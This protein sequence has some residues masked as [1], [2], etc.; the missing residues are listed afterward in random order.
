MIYNLDIRKNYAE[1]RLSLKTLDHMFLKAVEDGANCSPF[2]A[3]AILSIVKKIYPVDIP[4]DD[5]NTKPGQMKVI[6]ISSD[7]P[8]GKPLSK[9]RMKECI[10]TIHNGKEDDFIRST[11]GVEG[12]R[13][14]VVLRIASQAYE[15][16]VLLTQEDIAFHILHCGRRTLNRDIAYFKEHNI[17]VPTR[18][19]KCDIGPGVSHK[20]KSV[21][22]LFQRKNEYEIA[23]L[24][25]HTVEAIER[26]TQT[27]I[28]IAF[29]CRQGFDPVDIAFTLH[30]SQ[31]LAS[32]YIE[33]YHKYNN[34]DYSQIL[35]EIIDKHPDIQS[36]KI[37][38]D[39]KKFQPIYPLFQR[40][41]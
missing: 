31:R 16:G 22:L 13:R 32:Q 14:A 23:R 1:Q 29:L 20:V 34:N 11:Q 35:Q 28:R 26:Y 38:G 6:G 17:F 33:L 27:F 18:G 7:E 9:C 25:Y 2:E 3:Q 5:D 37:I 39:K 12:L 4:Q 36:G 19:Q 40:R 41:K 15:Q 8:C 21:E 10:V 30:I 24:L